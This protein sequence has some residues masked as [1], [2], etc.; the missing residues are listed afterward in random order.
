MDS[1]VEELNKRGMRAMTVVEHLERHGAG[2][3]I[4]NGTL[5]VA[6]EATARGLDLSLSHVFVCSSLTDAEVY[7]HLAGRTGRYHN[8]G[9]VI[10]LVSPYDLSHLGRLSR[11][12]RVRFQPLDIGFG[13]GFGFKQRAP[14][15]ER[16]KAG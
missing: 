7:V 13:P 6:T 5:L 16:R 3:D 14:P 2:T 9:V 1:C 8:N 11:E 10:S 15:K 12:L 4:P